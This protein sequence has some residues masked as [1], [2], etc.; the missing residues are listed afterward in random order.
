MR[1]PRTCLKGVPSNVRGKKKALRVSHFKEGMALRQGLF[2]VHIYTG[3]GNEA[4]VK[5]ARQILFN[6]NASAACVHKEG[7]TLHFPHLLKADKPRRALIVRGVDGND[8][9]L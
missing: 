7:R 2:H 5:G 4:L 9:G 3:P 6:G 1:Q 8:I